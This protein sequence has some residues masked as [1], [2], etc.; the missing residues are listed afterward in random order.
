M[1]N[2]TINTLF[3]EL[4]TPLIADASLRLKVPLRI[5]PAGIMPVIAGTTVA[6]RVLP[7][8]HYGSVDIFLEAIDAA[9]AGD[10]LVI[11]NERRTDE[12]CIGDLTVA[13]ARIGGLAGIVVWGAHRDT[14]EL[15]QIGFPVFSYSVCPS[16]PLRLDSRHADAFIS[17]RFGEF[18]VT[19]DDVVFADDDG[20]V[21]SPLGRVGELLEVATKIRT[22]ERQQADE[23]LRGNTLREQFSFNEFKA[24]RAENPSYTFREHLRGLHASI[25]E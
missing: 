22:T 12:G 2:E 19:G 5:A 20:C 11:D 4:S 17:A 16:G 14:S 15:K 9:K 6:G 1:N 10:V 3:A 7:V 8:R 13:E 23:I 24:K 18:E 21:F 25:E